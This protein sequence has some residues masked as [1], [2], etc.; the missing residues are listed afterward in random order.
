VLAVAYFEGMRKRRIGRSGVLVDEVTM[1]T[2]TFGLQTSSRDSL[3]ILDA[4]FDAGI[5][6]FDLAEIYPVPPEKK[7]QGRTEEIFGHWLQTKP[8]DSVIISSKVAGPAHG[9]FNPPVRFGTA[10]LDR[11]DLT[12]ALEGSLKRLRT[13]YLDLYQLHWPDPGMRVEDTLEVLD[14]FVRSGKVRV[15]GTSNETAWG[16]MRSLAAS[17]RESLKPFDFVQNH[18]SMMNRRFDDALAECC[19]HEQ[20]SLLAYSPLGG[21]VLTGKYLDGKSPDGARFTDYKK[22]S[23]PR[24]V[25][26]AQRFNNSQTNKLVKKLL[27]LSREWGVNPEHLAL[28]WVLRHPYVA[29]A[30]IG[31]SEFQQLDTFLKF[32]NS[33]LVLS[34]DQ[35]DALDRIAQ[36]SGYPMEVEATVVSASQAL[37]Q[38]VTY[39]DSE[40]TPEPSYRPNVGAIIMNDD[41]DILVCER[42][43][44]RGCWQFPQG[45]VDEGEAVDDAVF[46]EVKE[47]IG[48]DAKY[49]E[50]VSSKPGYRY[51]YPEE[52]KL[53]KK[54][55]YDGQNQTYF[56]L[57]I[58]PDAPD[59]DV[60]Q[61]KPEFRDY[62][63]IKPS[64]FD[65]SW[66]PDFKKVAFRQVFADFFEV[67][68]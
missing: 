52:V 67:R 43:K 31:V 34:D 22:Y 38:P 1:G 64:A 26:M 53:K 59:I 66:V 49:L 9:W 55:G 16:L 8:R 63:W 28:S 68:L 2:M 50:V 42:K 61:P 57:K 20:V 14:E 19:E 25:A 54:H 5:R 11:R 30:I 3:K 47:E 24:Q 48:L 13:D 44:T 18:Y 12:K 29:S 40:P 21:G 62:Q 15:I 37:A 33:P 56:L 6:T 32:W 17:E 46:R 7:N 4:A 51:I 10:A 27:K 58:S 39:G 45:G 36:A 65:I 60:H 35:L 41:G 23:K